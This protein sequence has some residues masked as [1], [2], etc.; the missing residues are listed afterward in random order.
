LY[1]FRVLSWRSLRLGERN[2]LTA[3]DASRRDAKIAEKSSK[4]Q[5]RHKP[6]L[7]V[8][9]LRRRILDWKELFGFTGGFLTTMGMV[10]Q[11][12]RLFKLKS[13]HEISMAFTVLYSLGIALW[14]IYGILNGLL[15][16]II[17]NTMGL[18]LCCGMLYAKIRWG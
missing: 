11:I 8:H 13:A 5:L 9:I 3:K 6:L 7:T 12:W 15:S 17:W 4:N 1:F 2:A 10:P 16:V 18:L 14:L